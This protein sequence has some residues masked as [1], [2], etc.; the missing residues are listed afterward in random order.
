[1]VNRH[2]GSFRHLIYLQEACRVKTL[3]SC[4]HRD[5]QYWP[6][7]ALK[8][9]WNT[10]ISVI[11]SGKGWGNDC[12]L[13]TSCKICKTL[14]Q[15][16]VSAQWNRVQ[17]TPV[18]WVIGSSESL[19]WRRKPKTLRSRWSGLVG[20]LHA[21]L[22]CASAGSEVNLHVHMWTVII[23]DLRLQQFVV[24]PESLFSLGIVRGGYLVDKNVPWWLMLI[25]ITKP[26]KCA[27]R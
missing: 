12:L 24:I 8:T 2:L 10:T 6:D 17:T 22:L 27:L 11:S 18:N 16:N 9:R 7:E 13:A 14:Q 15:V 3:T 4:S 23:S 19:R 26:V 25:C 1:M 20:V 21:G 5:R